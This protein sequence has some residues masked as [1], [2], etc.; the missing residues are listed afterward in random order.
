M[1]LVTPG[2]YE[3]LKKCIDEYDVSELSKLNQ[4]TN[5]D[6]SSTSDEILRNI[7]HDEITS[8]SSAG[9]TLQNNYTG[10]HLIIPPSTAPPPPPP[11]PSP[12]LHS[13]IQHNF[14]PPSRQSTLNSTFGDDFNPPLNSTSINDISSPSVKSKKIEKKG[15]AYKFNNIPKMSYVK[16]P[17]TVLEDEEMQE[18]MSETFEPI[19]GP[20]TNKQN[21]FAKKNFRSQHTHQNIPVSIPIIQNERLVIHPNDA[22]ISW[23]EQSTLNTGNNSNDTSQ[24]EMDISG[25]T[26]TFNNSNFS[27]NNQSDIGNNS[28]SNLNQSNHLVPDLVVNRPVQ[29]Q[30]TVRTRG[31]KRNICNSTLP[32]RGCKPKLKTKFFKDADI[33]QIKNTTILDRNKFQCPLCNRSYKYVTSLNRHTQKFH[34]TIASKPL[35]IEY[36]PQTQNQSWVKLGKR[37]GTQAGF[38]TKSTRK[39]RSSSDDSSS[40]AGPKQYKNTFKNWRV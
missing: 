2:V 39:P 40:Q 18:E 21:L 12:P 1:Y 13:N 14:P 24:T 22:N 38:K 33:S 37:T 30:L 3:K 4:S 23:V 28:I 5:T 10:A 34:T 36:K 27:L 16:I 29:P 25:D 17:E 9:E 26:S 7:S 35:A 11:P 32:L 19:P 20:S 31:Q 15:A 8:N 6:T